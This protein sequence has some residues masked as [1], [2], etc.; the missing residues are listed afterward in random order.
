MPKQYLNKMD[1][2]YYKL[3][4]LTIGVLGILFGLVAIFGSIGFIAIG[5][6]YSK[7]T[8]LIISILAVLGFV[9]GVFEIIVFFMV[10]KKKQW[11]IIP[12]VILAGLSILSYYSFPFSQAFGVGVCYFFLFDKK[13]K[14]AYK[15]K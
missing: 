10:L 2:K 13:F 1:D 4:L 5:S 11:A 8:L 7:T 14:K 12:A 15:E 6:L 9:L 3:I